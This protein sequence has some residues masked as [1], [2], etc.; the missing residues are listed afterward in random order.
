MMI[1]Y[2]QTDEFYEHPFWF[3]L[4]YMVP[5]FIIFRTRLY[6]AWILSE[7]MCMTSGLGAYPEASQPKC[8]QGPTDLKKL[9]ERFVFVVAQ[10]CGMGELCKLTQFSLIF[11]GT[12]FSV[13]MENEFNANNVVEFNWYIKLRSMIVAMN[14]RN[15]LSITTRRYIPCPSTGASWDGPQ[16]KA[17][18]AGIWPSSTGWPPTVIAEYL[19]HLKPIG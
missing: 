3:R 18:G 15:L 2:T 17:S 4:F 5:M 6:M 9:H 7:S 16:R 8:G 13:D 12:P 11:I 14:P 1:Q 10:C 19:T